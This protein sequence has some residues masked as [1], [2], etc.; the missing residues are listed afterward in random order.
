LHLE[1]SFGSNNKNTHILH[2]T[3]YQLNVDRSIATI[4][5]EI[6]RNNIGFVNSKHCFFTKI[7][8]GVIIN[9][10]L[11]IELISGGDNFSVVL[12]G[13]VSFNLEFFCREA[14]NFVSSRTL[15]YN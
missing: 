8:E 13:F 4:G 14:R 3:C 9:K 7:H 1:I 5:N 12:C 2:T 11:Q 10:R 15:T 6:A